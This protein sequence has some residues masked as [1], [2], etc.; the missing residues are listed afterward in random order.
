MLVLAWPNNPGSAAQLI[1]FAAGAFAMALSA[2]VAR[3]YSALCLAAFLW[4][5]LWL[6]FIV[7]LSYLPALVEPI[8][9][10][11][12]SIGQYDTVMLA[13]GVAFFA[14][15]LS[16]LLAPMLRLG[17]IQ[18]GP[19]VAKLPYSVAWSQFWTYLAL[20]GLCIAIAVI[21]VQLGIFQVGIVPLTILP[22]PGNALI[23]LFLTT[24]YFFAISYFIHCDLTKGRSVVAGLIT[25]ILAAALMSCSLLSRGVVVFHVA[26]VLLA[27]AGITWRQRTGR[28]LVLFA[29]ALVL[30]GAAVFT[31]VGYV[32]AGRQIGF[33]PQTGPITEVSSERL[34]GILKSA[35][36]A[37]ANNTA[38]VIAQLAVGRWIGVE[39]VMVA[40]GNAGN[41]PEL[42]AGMLSERAAIGKTGQY[43]YLSNSIYVTQNGERFQFATLPGPVGAFLFSGSVIYVFFGMLVLCLLAMAYEKLSQLLSQSVFITCFIAV[44][45]A[46]N[47]AQF[48]LAPVN[49][50]PQIGYMVVLLVGFWGARVLAPHLAGMPL[51]HLLPAPKVP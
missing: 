42:M 18:L 40:A 2:A 48:G 3:S 27:L 39:G 22:K 23:S 51:R 28:A 37:G 44:F 29:G 8:G 45:A 41:S 35:A 13:S 47:V 11:D 32:E 5:G 10:F 34:G 6:K 24:G 19:D 14:A 12:G 50:L 17:T 30:S 38:K 26:S 9:A 43:Q 46:N 7:H 25:L 21:N 20:L 15:A 31:T 36:F 1:F 33:A 4:L 49:Q 16:F